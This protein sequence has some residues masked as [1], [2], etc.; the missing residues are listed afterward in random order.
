MEALSPG[1]AGRYPVVM[2]IGSLSD[3]H[4]HVEMA[5]AAI[6]ILS[7]RG[8][9]FFF[10]CGDVGGE[11]VIDELAGLD[12][13]FVWGNNDWDREDLAAYA[14]GLGIRCFG[15]FGELELD[16]KF[17]AV[18]HGDD[19]KLKRQVLDAQRHDFLLLG[20]THVRLDERVGRVRVVN[21][22]ALY[23]AKPPTVALLNTATDA[24]EFI[25]VAV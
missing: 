22:G 2:L 11:G 12:A 20:H 8:A 3:T 14:T 1:C 15:T 5:R 13:A 10:H 17:F 24:I 25:E 9:E 7:D 18:L 21:P 4:D 23:R 6:R 19:T 16:G